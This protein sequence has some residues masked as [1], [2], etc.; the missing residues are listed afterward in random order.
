M[1]L[2][3][4][5]PQEIESCWDD[6]G[7]LFT[8]LSGCD[9]TS[10]QIKTNAKDSRQ[11]IWGLQDALEVHGVCITEIIQTSRGLVCLIV[12]A[13]GQDIPKPLMERLHDEIGH[14]AKDLGC[15][16]MR[17]HG[18]KGWLRWDRRYKQTG[19]VAERPL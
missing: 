2:F 12:G 17:I 11:Q 3:C 7:A 8:R 1:R 15:V 18:R 9:L 16:A 5:S 6:F 13:C 10:E 4:L 19:I 14:W